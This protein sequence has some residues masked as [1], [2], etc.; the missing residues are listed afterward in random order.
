MEH[1]EQQGV[2]MKL[3]YII[4]K[5]TDKN[6]RYKDKHIERAIWAGLGQA[7][8]GY[9]VICPHINFTGHE[10]LMGYKSIM[11][12]CE[13]IIK[14]VDKVYVLDNWKTS[15]GSQQEIKIAQEHNKEIEWENPKN[16]LKEEPKYNIREEK[17]ITTNGRIRRNGGNKG[18]SRY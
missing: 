14:R 10:K 1:E 4:G 2:K 17:I 6:N 8:K 16:Q 7:L 18:K 11:R 9:A 13:E 5:Y 12:Q 15:K 3:V